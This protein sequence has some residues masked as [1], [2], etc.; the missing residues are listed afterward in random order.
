MSL[1]VID[2]KFNFVMMREHALYDLNLLEF[3]EICSM[4]QNMV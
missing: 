2:F 1:S 3:I 4:A